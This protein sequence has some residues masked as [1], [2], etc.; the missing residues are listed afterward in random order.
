[1]IRFSL[2][3]YLGFNSF[4]F[5]F[6]FLVGARIGLNLVGLNRAARPDGAGRGPGKKKIRLINGP[7][8]GLRAESGPGIEKLDPNPTRCHSY[9]LGVSLVIDDGMRN[10]GASAA[11]GQSLGF[12]FSQHTHGSSC[13]INNAPKGFLRGTCPVYLL[14]FY[15]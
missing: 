13:Q 10:V 12:L 7:G 9:V 8:P 4:S 6:S 11:L 14:E 1:M 3:L 15:R 5:F 2:G